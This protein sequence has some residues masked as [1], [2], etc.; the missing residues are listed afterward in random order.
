MSGN[1]RVDRWYFG[2]HRVVVENTL[3]GNPFTRSLSPSH[4]N[5]VTSPASPV[6]FRGRHNSAVSVPVAAYIATVLSK[7]AV[8]SWEVLEG[9]AR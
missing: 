3:M 1:L 7:M 4:T 8:K 6:H 5:S 9:P 2:P